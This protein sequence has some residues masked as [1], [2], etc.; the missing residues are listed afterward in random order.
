M[1]TTYTL[2]SKLVCMHFTYLQ[3]FDPLC[4]CQNSQFET[5][6]IFYPLTI[7]LNVKGHVMLNKH[8]YSTISPSTMC[9]PIQPC[10]SSCFAALHRSVSTH[11]QWRLQGGARGGHV[12]PWKILCP[13]VCP[14]S[15]ICDAKFCICHYL[16][17]PPHQTAV[18]PLC[19]PRIKSLVTPLSTCVYIQ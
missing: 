9:R 7:F 1:E 10:T 5:N 13:P 18:P 8:L 14:P 12:P 11:L 4:V 19:P 3:D 2:Q 16:V 15:E 17:V 6:C